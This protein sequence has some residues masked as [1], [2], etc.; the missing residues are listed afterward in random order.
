MAHLTALENRA[1]ALAGPDVLRSPWAPSAEDVKSLEQMHFDLEECLPQI[2]VEIG[3]AEAQIRVLEEALRQARLR[4]D[5]LVSQR[6][7]IARQTRVCKATAKAFIRRLPIE[8]MVTIFSLVLEPGT[9]FYGRELHSIS[10]AC[11]WWRSVALS[12]PSLWSTICLA[13]NTEPF[14]ELY[15]RAPNAALVRAQLKYSADAPLHVTVMM[16]TSGA[17]ECAHAAYDGCWAAVCQQSHRWRTAKI[18]WYCKSS[19]RNASVLALPAL[20]SL[21]ISDPHGKAIPFFADAPNLRTAIVVG[22]ARVS[23]PRPWRL[24][25]LTLGKA[26][27]ADGIPVLQQL[28]QTLQCLTIPPSYRTYTTASHCTPISLPGLSFLGFGSL[29][30]CQAFCPLLIVPMLVELSLNM[31]DFAAATCDADERIVE[32]VR[33]SSASVTDL[34]ICDP[35]AASSQCL[36]RLLKGL[37]TLEFLDLYADSGHEPLDEQFFLA[38]SPTIQN[39]DCPLPNLVELAVTISIVDDPACMDYAMLYQMFNALRR[40]DVIINGQV[41]PA[42][43]KRSLKHN[44]GDDIFAA[45][46]S[47]DDDEEY[48]PDPT[49][50]GDDTDYSTDVSDDSDEPQS[51]LDIFGTR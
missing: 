42:L 17:D 33:R 2:G 31:S 1:A 21:T 28:S 44:P 4:L 48:V 13:W 37:P 22:F 5:A 12:T 3:D 46:D 14:H 40:E 9:Y 8:V 35:N 24:T 11:S 38:L 30:Q 16:H 50:T 41:Y 43:E 19:W 25:S 15:P 23:C 26:I 47:D 6:E 27:P 7:R 18:S 20:E 45:Y 10:A 36:L 49:D 51:D 39:P 34:V 29:N 32:M